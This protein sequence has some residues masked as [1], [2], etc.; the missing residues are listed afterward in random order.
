M[1]DFI[2]KMM[3]FILK[4]MDF[5]LNNDGFYTAGGYPTLKNVTAQLKARGVNVLLPYNPWHVGE[6]RQRPHCIFNRCPW[7]APRSINRSMDLWP[8]HIQARMTT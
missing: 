3:N 1:M 8:L 4:M 7:P 6:Y 5:M 2:P